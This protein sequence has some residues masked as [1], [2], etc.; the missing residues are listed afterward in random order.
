MM[1]PKR[2]CLRCVGFGIVWV[3]TVRTLDFALCLRLTHL[4]VDA[5]VCPDC[6]GAGVVAQRPELTLIQ[7]GKRG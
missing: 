1:L 4:D 3:Q 2:V 5:V 7:G 6:H